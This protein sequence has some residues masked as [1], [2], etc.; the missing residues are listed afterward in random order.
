MIFNILNNKSVWKLLLLLSY[1]PGAGYTREEL[2]NLLN[3]NNLSLD[4]SL[5]KLL[6][7]HVIT[8]N[9]RLIKLNF[10]NSQTNSLLELVDSEKKRLNQ[11]NFELFVSLINIVAVLEKH[12]LS[13]A[14]LFGSYAKKIASKNSDIDIAVISKEKLSISTIQEKLQL[15]EEKV[16]THF[17][18]ENDFKK[19][20]PLVKEILKDGIELL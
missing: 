2:L 7:Y 6:F 10:N 3:W 16:Q 15:V 14:Y 4:R 11:P 5:K 13:K 1:S 19:D 17:F 20:I 18:L 9:K 12:K 8:K